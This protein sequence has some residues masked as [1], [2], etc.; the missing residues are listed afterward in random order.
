MKKLLSIL[1]TEL[2]EAKKAWLAAR[3][4]KKPE[5]EVGK[6]LIEYQA[7]Q[8]LVDGFIE[9]GKKDTDEVEIPGEKGAD[10]V[11]EL[12]EIGTMIKT[13]V[14]T[15][16]KSALP[17]GAKEQITEAGIKAIVLEAIKTA[18]ADETKMDEKQI[19][20]L[21]GNIVKAAL[22]TIHLPSKF[23]TNADDKGAT[24][25]AAQESE[26]MKKWGV[27]EMPCSLRKGNLPLHLKQ[28]SNRLCGKPQD[29]GIDTRDLERGEKLGDYMFQSLK[30]NGIKALTSTGTGT[31]SEWVPRNLSSELYRR[32]YLE[33]QIAQVLQ[34]REITQPS[35]P[36][37]LP[38]STTRP[39][40][41][42]NS[43]QNKE[44]LPSTPGSAKIT[45]TTK[46]LIALVQYSYE[47]NEDAII[48]ILP[49]IETLIGE[50][51]AAA[52]ENALINGDTTATHQDNDVTDP[53]DVR[54]AW[55]GFRKLAIAGSLTVDI[56]TGG[57]SRSNLLA[58]KKKLDKWGVRPGD[59][60]WIVPSMTASDF[61]GLDDVVTVYAHGPEATHLT[62]MLPSYY[63]T[64]ITV[65]EQCREDLNASGVY[66]NST[67]TKGAI[68]LVNQTQFVTGVKREFTIE[69]DRNIRSQTNDIVA[70]FRKSFS[71]TDVPSSTIKTLAMGIN[72]SV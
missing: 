48:P 52:Y 57:V 13:S 34:A 11:V 7:K 59:L 15:A 58:I 29:E 38:F 10:N 50:A 49:L 35:D 42:M 17:D 12:S 14:E 22:K 32:L 61:M 3:K 36:Y 5:A 26:D 21:T 28:L 47:A 8:V 40:F 18:K 72:Y 53:N 30:Q 6:L 56:S 44:P 43:V 64:P 67:K 23:P 24:G 41:Y 9:E 20:E 27:I 16:L 65:S 46:K 33:S 25:K 54:K 66:D 62:G 2:S 45:L 69:V 63:G 31:G 37:D 51:A 1:K 39:T 70:S 55:N 68:L 60:M 71:P 4:A 19:T